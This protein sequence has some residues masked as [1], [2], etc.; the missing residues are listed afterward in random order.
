MTYWEF[1][2]WLVEQAKNRPIGV[3]KGDNSKAQQALENQIA[4]RQLAMQE[5]TFNATFPTI[6]QI[7]AGR[8]LLP[9]EEAAL[10]AHLINSLPQTYNNLYGQIGQQLTARGVTGGQNAGGGDIARTFGSLGASEAGQAQQGLF[11]IAQLKQQGLGA[12]LGLGTTQMGQTGSTAANILGSASQSAKAAD[13]ASSG[14]WG[15]LFGALTSPFKVT[16]G[17]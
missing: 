9:Q 8:G 12:A 1:D 11:D 3:C 4:Q 2:A 16:K 13:E 6:Q 5:Q 10:N 7:I 15:S 17:F 14:F